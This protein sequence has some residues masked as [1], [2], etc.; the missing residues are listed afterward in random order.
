MRDDIERWIDA[1]P[2]AVSWV[3]ALYESRREQE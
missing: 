3:E 2:R 1:F